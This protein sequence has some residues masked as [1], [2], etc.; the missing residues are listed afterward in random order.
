MFHGT[1]SR[2]TS[3]SLDSSQLLL[4]GSQKVTVVI[5]LLSA[6][7]NNNSRHISL[8]DV[9]LTD[10]SLAS[11]PKFKNDW[12]F[13]STPCIRFYPVSVSETH[14]QGMNSNHFI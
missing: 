10:H 13:T 2:F 1:V 14:F 3:R 4:F 12:S 6:F 7:V 9:I 8:Y 11:G 5:A